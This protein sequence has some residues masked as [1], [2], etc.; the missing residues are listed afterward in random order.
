VTPTNRQQLWDTAGTERFRSVS[1]SYYRGAAGAILVYDVTSHASFRALP[2]FLADARALA[3]PQLTILLAGNKS[4]ISEPTDAEGPPTPGAASVDSRRSALPPQ[5]SHGSLQGSSGG[6]GF[7]A[8][9]TATTAAD[10]REVSLEEA[11]EWASKQ[12]IPVAVE[13]SALTGE[14]VEEIFG[15]LARTILTRIELGE[16]NPD[17]PASGIQYGDTGMW[18]DGGS[19]KSGI[20][21]DDGFS[22]IRRRRKRGGT[23]NWMGGVQEWEEV[24]RV[25]SSRGRRRGCC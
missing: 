10:G 6:G 22:G 9:N 1:R 12:G 18:E 14:N 7:G 11:S 3:S 17:D 20:T 5:S 15:R 2:T 24:F 13:V 25:G 19:V 23:N 8:Q 4:D 21:V 16:I